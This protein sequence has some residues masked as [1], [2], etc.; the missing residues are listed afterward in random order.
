M[1]WDCVQYKLLQTCTILEL[2]YRGVELQVRTPT[3]NFYQFLRGTFIN[4]NKGDARMWLA[5]PDVELFCYLSLSV[6]LRG[7]CAM[8]VLQADDEA[9]RLP[10]QGVLRCRLLSSHLPR[11]SWHCSVFLVEYDLHISQY[12]KERTYWL[13]RIFYAAREMLLQVFSQR[14][15]GTFPATCFCCRVS[16]PMARCRFHTPW[17]PCNWWGGLGWG[18]C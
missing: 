8:Q 1:W 4:R 9:S 3:P 10:C 6:Q 13:D 14:F 7:R 16:D 11:L 18:G 12:C 5:L 15:R 2:H 17:M